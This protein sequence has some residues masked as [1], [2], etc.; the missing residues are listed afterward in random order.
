MCT[1]DDLKF[2]IKKSM[3]EQCHAD[4][5]GLIFVCTSNFESICSTL[6]FCKF[7]DLLQF[8]YSGVR[9]ELDI[10]LSVNHL[11]LYIYELCPY[12]IYTCFPW[13]N[14]LNMEGFEATLQ[15]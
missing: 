13:G 15:C 12:V 11:Y 1:F 5:R 7:T 14:F 3:S 9:M 2:F 6:L 10:F 4:G 8:A